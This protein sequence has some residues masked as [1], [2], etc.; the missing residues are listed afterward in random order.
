MSISV[1]F[2]GRIVNMGSAVGRL[3]VP[4]CSPYCVSK[5]AVE[6]FT[7]CL[8]Y[9]MRKFHVD[10]SIIEPGHYIAATNIYTEESVNRM[11]EI[12]WKSMS[13]EV[14]NAYTKE[15]FDS[16]VQGMHYYRTT[17][18]KDVSPV[19]D[20]LVDALVSRKPRLRYENKELYWHV[21]LFA[22]LHLPECIGDYIF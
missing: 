21:R 20:S 11:G 13:D 17:G 14:R 15:Y 8:R 3:A 5:Y 22:V 12:M 7:Q 10:V 2:S 9:E 6:G 18:N 1:F 16:R 19:I 4:D